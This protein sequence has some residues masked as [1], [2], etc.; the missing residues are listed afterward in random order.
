MFDGV[1]INNGV[2]PPDQRTGTAIYLIDDGQGGI[3][4]RIAFIN[5]IIRMVA[6]LPTPEGDTDGCAY[7][8]GNARDVLFA[9]NNVMTAGNRNSW[10][11]RISGGENY[12]FIDNSV[13]VSFHKLIR[14]NDG[15][16]DYVY[17][18]NG[19]WMREATLTSGGLEL[20]DSFAQLGDLGTDNVYIHDVEIPSAV[21]RAGR[22]RGLVRSRADRQ[23]L[24][25]AAHRLAR[26]RRRRGRRCPAD[27][28]PGRLHRGR[29]L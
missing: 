13:R 10:G 25:G 17:V 24:G 7:L 4:E 9:N 12:I 26:P 1:I 22:V 11:F 2:R 29:H 14:M 23:A 6:T 15:P 27:G 5:S 16:V 18:K 8:A 28:L 21:G 20:N 19:L 3:V